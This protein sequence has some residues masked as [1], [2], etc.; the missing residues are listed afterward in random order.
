MAMKKYLIILI[1]LIGVGLSPIAQEQQICA[2]AQTTSPNKKPRMGTVNRDGVAGA[3]SKEADKLFTQYANNGDE[4]GIMQMLLNGSLVH[5]PKGE[6]VTLI[7]YG[8]AS[9]K[10]RT[11]KGQILYVARE[12]VTLDNP[13]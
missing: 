8:F 2:S 12:H 13:Q 9:L 10:I 3:I 1:L 5:L 11:K 6:R 7:E 4:D